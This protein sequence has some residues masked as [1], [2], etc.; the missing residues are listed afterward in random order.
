LRAPGGF[1]SF[2]AASVARRERTTSPRALKR[3]KQ[4]AACRETALKQAAGTLAAFNQETSMTP[5]HI[6]LVR[7]S[8]GLVA[9]IAPQAAA[10]FYD[11][12][13]DADPS[14]R[15]LFRG[16]NMAHQ[17]ERLMTMIATAVRMLDQPQVLLPLLRSLGA[18][19]GGYGVTSD[20]YA[21]VGAA[22]LKTLEQGLQDAW[23]PAA[24]EAWTAAYGVISR[25]MQEGAQE[26][27]V[28]A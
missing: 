12:L 23:T 4:S 13:F 24:A 25:T 21:T 10:L 28:A 9:P 16:G 15:A 14:L 17:G 1:V 6:T 7:H 2:V 20:H 19:H 22:L 3:L 18:R 27:L 5:S 26:Q 11:N 8:F